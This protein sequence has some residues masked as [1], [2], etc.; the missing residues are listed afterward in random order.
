MPTA[1]RGNAAN[2]MMARPSA[3]TTARMVS[4]VLPERAFGAELAARQAVGVLSPAAPAMTRGT[5]ARTRRQRRRAICFGRARSLGTATVLVGMAATLLRWWQPRVARREHHKGG[6]AI[7]ALHERYFS[8]TRV[9]SA[10]FP[11]G[12]GHGALARC[13]L[14]R[15]GWHVRGLGQSQRTADI[16]RALGWLIGGTWP[17]CGSVI[18]GASDNAPDIR[19]YRRPASVSVPTRRAAATSRSSVAVPSGAGCSQNR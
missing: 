11:A 4:I 9:P 13:G 6:C 7:S 18:H 17:Q 19:P 8:A 5:A 16:A 15:P 10:T 14:A 3:A 2:T 1:D 12:S